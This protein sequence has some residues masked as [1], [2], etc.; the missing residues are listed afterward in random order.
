MG[1]A[2]YFSPEQ[3][4]GIAI[5]ARSDVYALGVV[6]YEMLAGKPP[7]TG[8]NPVAIAFQ[9]VKEAPPPLRRIGR[10]GAHRA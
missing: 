5:D 4:Q 7:F 6:L 8:E 9:H 3:A 2:T 1:T 10:D